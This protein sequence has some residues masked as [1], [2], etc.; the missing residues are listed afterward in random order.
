MGKIVCV[1]NSGGA[2]FSF[3]PAANHREDFFSPFLDTPHNLNLSAIA[4][5]LLGGNTGGFM[6]CYYYHTD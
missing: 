4:A 3:L 6:S 5:G 2:I 1:N